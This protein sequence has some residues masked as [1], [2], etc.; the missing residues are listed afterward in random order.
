M[1][2]ATRLLVHCVLENEIGFWK[3]KSPRTLGAAPWVAGAVGAVSFVQYMR[4]YSPVGFPSTSQR[5]PL[6]TFVI[7]SVNT[8]FMSLGLVHKLQ[9]PTE[10]EGRF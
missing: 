3:A 8:M 6:P 4:I 10:G 2:V 5:L 7:L 9:Q 1:G